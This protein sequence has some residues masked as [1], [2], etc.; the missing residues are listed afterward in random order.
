[1]RHQSLLMG[2]RWLHWLTLAHR[3]QC[4]LRVLQTDDPE[5]PLSRWAARSGTRCSAILYLGYVEVRLQIPGIR[6]YNETSCCWWHWQWPILRR[7]QSW[8]VQ[9]Y[10]Q[11]NGNDH[12]R[13]TSEGNHGLETGPLWWSYVWVTPTAPQRCRGDGGAAKG[14]NPFAGL[15]S[16]VLKEFCLDGIQGHIHTTWR[17]TIPPFG[18]L[19]ICSKTDIWGHSMWVYM[20][21]KPAWGTQLSI[22]IAPTAT[23]GELHPGFSQVPICLRKLSTAPL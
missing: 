4:E 5:G 6:E 21:A 18:T 15:N 12:K 23:Y 16:T 14:T 11:G 13:G 1:M 22:P 10:W 19:N 7:Y 17:V 8:G 2:R 9:E 3:T 20:L